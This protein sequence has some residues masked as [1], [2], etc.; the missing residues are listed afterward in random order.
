M[1]KKILVVLASVMILTACGSKDSSNSS[2][3]GSSSAGAT[4]SASES[5]AV[6]KTPTVT[7]S[8]AE[9]TANLSKDIEFTSEMMMVA[10][11]EIGSFIEIDPSIQ[12]SLYVVNGGSSDTLAVFRLDDESK[13]DGL[14][15]AIEG[16]MANLKEN[17]EYG[18][19]EELPKLEHA[20]VMDYGNYIVWCI[21]PDALKAKEAI[22]KAF[23]VQQ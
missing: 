17:A 9:L 5:S 14:R 2:S 23:S 3:S 15:T 21:A 16:Y 20:L 11:E 19:P 8:P 13:K 12:A 22:N 18:N 4:S 1:L 7:A 6:D 10:E